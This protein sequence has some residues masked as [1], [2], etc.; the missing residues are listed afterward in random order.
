MILIMVHLSL[1]ALCYPKCMN[2]GVCTAPGTC[3]CAEGYI[4]PHC[5]GGE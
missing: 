3:S 1:L 5:E 4:G 2:G